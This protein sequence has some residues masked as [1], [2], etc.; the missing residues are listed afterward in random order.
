M[1]GALATGVLLRTAPRISRRPYESA[2][3]EDVIHSRA[4]Q[5]TESPPWNDKDHPKRLQSHE[6]SRVLS[7][8]LAVWR[9][10]YYTSKGDSRL[11]QGVWHCNSIF[12]SPEHCLI[13]KR[14]LLARDQSHTKRRQHGYDYR[15]QFLPQRYSSAAARF[16]DVRCWR[17]LGNPFTG[18]CLMY[19]FLWSSD[20]SCSY[21]VHESESETNNRCQREERGK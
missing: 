1:Q 12:R 21:F 16:L 19:L 2:V 18:S 3:H 13:D 5:G 10:A 11:A 9:P 7:S 4:M 17:L 6:A 20:S 14:G 8:C 15:L